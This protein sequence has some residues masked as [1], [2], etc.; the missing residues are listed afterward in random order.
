MPIYQAAS[1]YAPKRKLYCNCCHY[2]LKNFKDIE[3]PGQFT[4]S[5][6]NLFIYFT[7]YEILY[8][9]LESQMSST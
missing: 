3:D 7:D 8:Q 1:V 6:W 9:I 2:I 5:D 4:Y